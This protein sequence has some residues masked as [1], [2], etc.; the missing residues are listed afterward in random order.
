[1]PKWLVL[2]AVA[3]VLVVV[4]AWLGWSRWTHRATATAGQDTGCV[5]ACIAQSVCCSQSGGANCCFANDVCCHTATPHFCCA[6]EAQCC[7]AA[8]CAPDEPCCPVG[9]NQVTC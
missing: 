9:N 3:A 2:I 5:P 1:M 4:G 8:C 6:S 7:G